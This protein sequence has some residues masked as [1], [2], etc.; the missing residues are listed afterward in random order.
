MKLP[1]RLA[2]VA[3]TFY[4][5]LAEPQDVTKTKPAVTRTMLHVSRSL[6]PSETELLSVKSKSGAVATLIV[7]KREGRL[8][9][10]SSTTETKTPKIQD[11]P[12]LIRVAKSQAVPN[13]V[14][15]R[16]EPMYVKDDAAN[17]KRAR[18]LQTVGDDGIPVVEG[19]RVPDSPEDKKHTWRNA[20]VINGVLVPYKQSLTAQIPLKGENIEKKSTEKKEVELSSV[21]VAQEKNMSMFS[22]ND[23]VKEKWKGIAETVSSPTRSSPVFQPIPLTFPDSK[24][25][26]ANIASLIYKI[27]QKEMETRRKSGRGFIFEADRRM[28]ENVDENGEPLWVDSSPKEIW[29]NEGK[30]L[31]AER[32]QD[33]DDPTEE[34]K[35]Q[36]V[37]AGRLLH[38]QGSSVY[39]ISALYSTQP[40]RVSFEEG[41]RTPVLQYAHPELGVQPAK[42][43]PA[44]SESSQGT[45]VPPLSYF[46]NDPHADRSPYAYEPGMAEDTLGADASYHAPQVLNSI[47]THSDRESR[48][49]SSINSIELTT[50]EPEKSS[51]NPEQIDI[52]E[53]PDR[54]VYHNEDYRDSYGIMHDKYIKRYPYSGYHPNSYHKNDFYKYKPGLGSGYNGAYYVKIPDNRPFWEKFTDS[55]KETVQTGMDT[56]KDMTRP[57]VDPIYQATQRIS[58]NLGINDATAK[59]SSTLGIN[60]GT[61]MRNVIQEKMGTAASAPI[62]LPALGL[63]AGGAALGLGAVAVGRLFDINVNLLRRSEHGDI[64]DSALEAEHKRALESIQDLPEGL[65]ESAGNMLIVPLSDNADVVDGNHESSPQNQRVVLIPI[66]RKAKF[67]PMERPKEENSDPSSFRKLIDESGLEGLER[68]HFNVNQEDSSHKPRRR[69]MADTKCKQ[70]PLCWRQVGKL[71]KGAS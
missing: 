1:M 43:A 69:A 55:I 56:V 67:V 34:E 31:V 9:Q 62:V 36:P 20:R 70:G 13:P 29:T 32:R 48:R 52:T 12:N 30:I 58:E 49:H 51:I 57:V 38:P 23:E 11:A 60:Q 37:A 8:S 46:S 15:I 19:I 59:I 21:Y 33:N 50:S 63:L 7:K 26:D 42:V 28:D 39:P 66:N 4:I 64:D 2:I 61:G 68:F 18:N 40:S 65:R 45:K 35:V 16:S 54:V 25:T 24:K 44:P 3:I 27:N 53:A 41:V 22:A 47:N 5:A 71:L 17:K 6:D 10:V 14:E